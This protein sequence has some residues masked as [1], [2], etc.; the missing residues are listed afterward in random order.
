MK[1]EYQITFADN[2]LF[3]VIHAFLSVPVQL[4]Y[5]A[6]A[7]ILFYI[8]LGEYPV[9]FIATIALAVYLVIWIIQIL[10]I[11]FFLCFGKNRSLY[12]R[13]RLEIQDGAFYTE[14][15]F[16]RSYIYWS[17]MAKVISPPGFIAVYFSA[18]A[19]H[20]IP[21]RAFSSTDEK[22]AFLAALHQKLSAAKS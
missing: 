11:T 14:S 15:Q 8:Y 17:G 21:N 13:H 16:G 20:V 6:H 1:L 2:V 18:N 4:F 10:F 9:L 19:A 5:F 12:A 22:R 7:A 3:N